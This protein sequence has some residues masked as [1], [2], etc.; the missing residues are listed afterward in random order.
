MYREEFYQLYAAQQQLLRPLNNTK[1]HICINFINISY[2]FKHVHRIT[3]K[4][5]NKKGTTISA[6]L[7]QI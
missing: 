4:Y 7:L 5:V 1:F 2:K 3:N 6:E